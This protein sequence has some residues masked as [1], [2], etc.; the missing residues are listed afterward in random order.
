MLGKGDEMSDSKFNSNIDEISKL[1]RENREKLN[2]LCEMRIASGEDLSSSPLILEE[3]EELDDIVIQK[4]RLQEMI[5]RQKKD[6][7]DENDDRN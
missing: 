3:S 2:R 4:A 7:A 5:D 6:G 1:L